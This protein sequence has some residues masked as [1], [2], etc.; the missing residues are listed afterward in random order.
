[1]R[2][3]EGLQWTQARHDGG[4]TIHGYASHQLLSV[5]TVNDRPCRWMAAAT[6]LRSQMHLPSVSS[7]PPLPAFC[8]HAHPVIRAMYLV[9]YGILGVVTGSCSVHAAAGVGSVFGW[10]PSHMQP[11]ACWRGC[12]QTGRQGQH[13]CRVSNGLHEAAEA[14]ALG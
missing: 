11:S 4:G 12:S 13:H 3:Q 1:M 7:P 5:A 8:L 6:A 9:Y 10:G 14:D 2:I